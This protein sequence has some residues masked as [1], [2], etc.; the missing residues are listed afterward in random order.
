MEQGVN[1]DVFEPVQNLTRM[2]RDQKRV[3]FL[4][5]MKLAAIF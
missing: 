2:T 1:F 5:I 4:T 3:D